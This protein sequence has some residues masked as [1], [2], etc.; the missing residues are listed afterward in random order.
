MNRTA[1]VTTWREVC[2]SDLVCALPPTGRTLEEFARRI[3]AAERERCAR[4]CEAEYVLA[5]VDENNGHPCDL[6]YNSA[7]RD[8]ARAIR[9]PP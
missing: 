8:A 7:L 5:S 2:G 6:A 4:L 3:E 1:A 9:K